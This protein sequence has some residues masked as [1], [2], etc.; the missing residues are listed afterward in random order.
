MLFNRIYV[1]NDPQLFKKIFYVYINNKTID[2]EI[3]RNDSIRY[4]LVTH[5]DS[6]IILTNVTVYCKYREKVVTDILDPK[7]QKPFFKGRVLE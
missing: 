7:N 1:N 2:Y 3:G 4:F 5:P 6:E